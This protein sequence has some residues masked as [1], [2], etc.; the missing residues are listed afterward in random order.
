MIAMI[1][2][3]WRHRQIREQWQ[4]EMNL[5]DRM[6]AYE[7]EMEEQYGP[8]WKTLIK[9]SHDPRPKKG[10]MTNGKRGR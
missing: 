6:A 10:M 9:R 7:A 4:R 2:P 5:A 8:G 3:E 1:L